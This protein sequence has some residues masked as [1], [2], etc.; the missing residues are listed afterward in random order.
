MKTVHTSE[1]KKLL[2][3]LR[4]RRKDKGLTMRALAQTLMIPHSWIGKVEI[5]ERRLDIVEFV[6]VC[7]VMGADPH[8]GLSL[9]ESNMRASKLAKPIKKIKKARKSRK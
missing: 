7:R 1:Y 5:G 8:A 3:W 6:K 2:T 4:E 9:L